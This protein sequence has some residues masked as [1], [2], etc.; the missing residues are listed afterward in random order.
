MV[1]IHKISA[2]VK[3]VQLDRVPTNYVVNVYAAKISSPLLH[4]H[5]ELVVCSKLGN[6]TISRINIMVF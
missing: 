1:E 4:I 6:F 5:D 3:W 2:A